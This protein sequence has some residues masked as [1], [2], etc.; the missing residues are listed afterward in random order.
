[1]KCVYVVRSLDAKGTGKE[2]RDVPLKPALDAFAITLEGRG[3]S[4][5]DVN[6]SDQ[7]HQVP[8]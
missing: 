1:V 5:R 7:W 2:R 6:L 8:D 4:T 3:S